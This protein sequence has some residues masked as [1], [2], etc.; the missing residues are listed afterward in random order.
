M[1]LY[2]RTVVDHYPDRERP[3]SADDHFIVLSGAYEVGGFHRIATGPSE[4]RWAWGASL[5]A[6]AA[7]FV[8]SGYA[9]SPDQCRILVARAFRRMLTRA[10]LRERPDAKPGP[11]RREPV[12]AIAEPSPPTQP[13]DRENDIRL[14]PMLRNER[15]I[16]IRSGELIVGLLARSTHGPETWSWALTGVERP[17]ADFRWRGEA[18]TDRDAFDAL[19]ASWLLWTRWAGLEP[20]ETL[21]RGTQPMMLR[22]PAGFIQPCLPSRAVRL[23][24]GPLWIHEIK[25]DGYRLMVRRDGPR[26]RC[27]TKNGYDWAARF[28]AIVDAAL[29]LKAQSFLIDGEA[30]IPRAD[31]MSNFRA[32]RSRASHDAVLFAFDLLLHDGADLR[33]LALIERKRR[34]ARLIGKAKQN[35]IRFVEHLTDDGAV[36]FE[37]ACRMGLE[38]IVSKRVDAPY[39]G[40]PSKVWLKS[41]NP[42]SEA[43]RREREEDWR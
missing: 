24:S 39:R 34:L 3:P 25:H 6:A 12:E 26:V 27:F 10:D 4:G 7:N 13:Y 17:F 19:A 41:K 1:P 43:V 42:A 15:H 38:G 8:A 28:P 11:P 31:G 14:G 2:A 36:V 29:R 37:H 33:D 30:V 5:G 40:G 20:I 21:Q 9:T 22:R 16:T 23:P 32:L 35:A 18:V